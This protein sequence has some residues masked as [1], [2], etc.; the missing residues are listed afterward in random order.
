MPLLWVI[1]PLFTVH[2][3]LLKV[4]HSLTEPRSSKTFNGS[5]FPLGW[6][7]ANFLSLA[8]DLK[9]GNNLSLQL[10]LSQ[11]DGLL[12]SRTARPARDNNERRV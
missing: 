10:P 9:D 6:V 4:H 5:S 2:E 1:V 7:L 3:D 8:F 12:A 11:A